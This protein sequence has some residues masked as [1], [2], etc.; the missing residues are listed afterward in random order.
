M[1]LRLWESL[2]LRLILFLI[3][4]SFLVWIKRF[5][6]LK[7]MLEEGATIIDIGGESTR[8]NADEVSEQEE[9]ASCCASSGSGAKPF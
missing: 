2:I 8:P 4:D 3:A 9:I 6:K 5:S 7:K 1:F